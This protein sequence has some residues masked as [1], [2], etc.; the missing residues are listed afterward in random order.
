MKMKNVKIVVAL[1]FIVS[2]TIAQEQSPLKVKEYGVGLSNLNSFSLQ[3][4][5]GNEKLIYR[6][7]AT[8]GGYSASG[9]GSNSTTANPVPGMP[10]GQYITNDTKTP[11]NFS[12]GLSFSVLKLKAINE[13]F[14]AMWG[15]VIGA[16]YF[17]N[18]QE[19]NQSVANVNGTPSPVVYGT[20]KTTSQR[21]QPYAGIALGV[22]YKINSSFIVYA[23]I[24][25]N[26]YYGYTQNKSNSTNNNGQYIS[27]TESSNSLNTY[28]I[29][30]I[31]NSGA[32][33]TFVYRITK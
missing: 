4:R 2:I 20:T 31:S 9:N 10:A 14:G 24:V 19:D 22:F 23:E 1:L 33:L 32:A 28:G 26:I 21:L 13:K 15:G 7:N 17:Y 29:S 25:P 30:N 18:N 27:K 16:S 12:S 3:Y 8:L 11:L 6:I 5:W